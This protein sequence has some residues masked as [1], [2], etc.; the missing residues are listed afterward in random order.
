MDRDTKYAALYN[1][2]C[3]ITEMFGKV[4]ETYMADMNADD[5]YLEQPMSSSEQEQ[6]QSRGDEQDMYDA[7]EYIEDEAGSDQELPDCLPMSCV[8]LTRD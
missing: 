1:K 6:T 7:Q 5:D 2:V 4:L 3:R 8:T